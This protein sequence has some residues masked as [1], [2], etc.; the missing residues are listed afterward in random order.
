MIRVERRAPSLQGPVYLWP[1]LLAALVSNENA[2]KPPLNTTR[3][4]IAAYEI[5]RGL[6][7]INVGSVGRACDELADQLLVES[8]VV[9][10]R[11]AQVERQWT[12][13][14]AGRDRYVCI[15]DTFACLGAITPTKRP[16]KTPR[17]GPRK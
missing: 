16:L 15:A 3:L 12:L 5:S 9:S 6:T 7:S 13:T 4:T 8:A 10:T 2:K 17:K 11:G 14:D 1:V